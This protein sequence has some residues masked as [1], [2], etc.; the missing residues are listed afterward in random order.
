MENSGRLPAESALA[1]AVQTLRNT[2]V[3]DGP[4]P[5]RNAELLSAIEQVAKQPRVTTLKKRVRTTKRITE[6]TIA[7]TLIAGLLSL[8]SWMFLESGSPTLAFA[9]V[10]EELAE[11]RAATC[12]VYSRSTKVD[13]EAKFLMV[14]GRIRIEYDDGRVLIEDHRQRKCMLLI[15][16]KKL[17][18][19]WNMDAR[20]VVI[21]KQA[22]ENPLGMLREE[23]RDAKNRPDG[24]VE[25]LGTK[26]IDGRAAVGFRF[27]LKGKNQDTDKTIWADPKTALPI[28]IEET[29]TGPG[30]SVV[31]SGSKGYRFNVKLDDSLFDIEPPEGYTVQ[32]RA[33]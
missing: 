25:N 26:Q 29:T 7:A 28:R 21:D 18:N 24:E 1:D 14:P 12:T 19:V 30:P 9:D 23:V 27:R 31:V 4:G 15:P 11:V 22:W 10:A 2:P 17:A 3:P 16:D 20:I 13:E 5:E 33:S 6:M 32:N 8:L